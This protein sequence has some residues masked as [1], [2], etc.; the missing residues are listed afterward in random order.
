MPEEGMEEGAPP[1]PPDLD[2][3]LGGVEGALE[4]MPPETAEEIRVHLNAIREIAAQGSA[5]MAPAEE[6]PPGSEAMPLPDGGASGGAMN[7]EQA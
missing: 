2:T 1:G 3:A 4:G 7:E 6:V 5:P